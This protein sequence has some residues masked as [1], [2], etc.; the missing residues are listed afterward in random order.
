MVDPPDGTD[1]PLGEANCSTVSSTGG[2]P[3]GAYCVFNSAIGAASLS[4]ATDKITNT[5]KVRL[6][7][8]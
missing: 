3:G 1:A 7:G 5:T 8:L 4:P 2:G 6:S